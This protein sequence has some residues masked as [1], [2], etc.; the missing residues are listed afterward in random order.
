[1]KLDFSQC[2]SPEDVE[3]V[4]ASAKRAIQTHRRVLIGLAHYDR[5]KVV[6]GCDCCFCEPGAR[7]EQPPQ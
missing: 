4:M 5:G 1:M 2:H 3:R 6:P 7:T